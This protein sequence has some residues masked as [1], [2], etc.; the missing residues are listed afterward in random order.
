MI[1]K[2]EIK[3]MRTKA[4]KWNLKGSCNVKKAPEYKQ[5]SKRIFRLVLRFSKNHSKIKDS[6][7]NC[8]KHTNWALQTVKW[9]LVAHLKIDTCSQKKQEKIL[10]HLSIFLWSSYVNTIERWITQHYQYT[11]EHKEI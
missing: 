2:Y 3:F 1:K 10:E 7:L 4:M 5:I 6:T 11:F 9:I 8:I